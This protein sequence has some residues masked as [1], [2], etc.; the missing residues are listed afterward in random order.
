[1]PRQVF[2]VLRLLLLMGAVAFSA[3]LAAQEPPPPAGDEDILERVL[4]AGGPDENQNADA[5]I[6]FDRTKVEMETSG[7]AHIYN[8]VLVKILTEKGADRYQRLRFDYDPASNMVEITKIRIIKDGGEIMTVP[9][10]NLLDLPQPQSMIMWG[11]RMKLVKIPRLSPGD[12]VEYETYKKGFMIAYLGEETGT[13]EDE[14]YIPPMRGHFY[15]IILFAAHFPVKEQYY[16]LTTPREQPAQ[17]EV[18]N[19]EIRAYVS[20]NEARN[21]YTFW[22]T[23]MAP[24]TREP[25]TPALSDFVPKVVLATVPS[26][27]EKSRWFYEVNEPV[28]AADES[29]REKVREMTGSLKSEEEKIAALLHWSAQEIRYSGISMGKGEGYTIHPSTM[30]F[31]DRCGVCKDK[32]GMLVTLLREAGYTVYPAMTMAGARVERIPADQFN[33]C[34]VALKKDD[35]S[36]RM[37]DPT[38]AVFSME[39][40]SSAESEQNYVIGSPDGEGLAV[41]P[42]S[43]AENNVL[44]ITAASELDQMGHL[45]GTIT[46]SGEGYMDQRLRRLVVHSAPAAEIQGLFGH[47][48][49]NI[50][51]QAEL[52]DVAYR[53]QDILD[54]SRPVRIKLQYAIPNYALP[55][56]DRLIFS[57]PTAHHFMDASSLAPYLSATEKA[58]RTQ[59]LALWCAR[60]LKVRE[61]I[62][63]PGE[64]RVKICPPGIS[65]DNEAASLKADY[66]QAGGKIEFTEEL[67]VRLRTYPPESYGDLKAVIDGARALPDQRLV[68]EKKSNKSEDRE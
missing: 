12:A 43:P 67:A 14:R 2:S 20:F 53:Y 34:V 68:L 26:W 10:D 3:M 46:L 18:Y 37:L 9:G 62:T 1:M 29:I 16:Q 47:F 33:H 57:P 30:T 60:T 48:L 64:Y 31:H 61:E 51:P 23:D 13:E 52:I 4:S 25:N 54:L 41:T 24:F 15:D 28:F 56:G 50:A 58:S 27:E 6:L 63:I 5:V 45:K 42:L 66:E 32:A 55:A 65:M 35:G 17:F 21:I 59:P 11:P 22:K 7:L 44:L 8:H 49:A 36:Y 19:G 38:W 39:L 40:W